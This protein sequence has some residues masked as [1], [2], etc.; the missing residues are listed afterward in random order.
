FSSRLHCDEDQFPSG[1][2]N[3]VSVGQL[4]NS[5]TANFR[6]R[7]MKTREEVDLI[8][9]SDYGLIYRER[10]DRANIR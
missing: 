4:Y 6:V 1:L 10:Q 2:S 9:S 7:F 5:G 8:K 3:H